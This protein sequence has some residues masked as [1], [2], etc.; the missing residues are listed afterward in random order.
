VDGNDGSGVVGR[1]GLAVGGPDLHGDASSS[2]GESV[3]ISMSSV[4][5]AFGGGGG[6][7]LASS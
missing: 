5:G 6:T 7:P 2:E 3:S 1:G 4:N